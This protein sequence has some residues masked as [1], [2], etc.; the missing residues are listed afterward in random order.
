MIQRY[1][2]GEDEEL[3]LMETTAPPLRALTGEGGGSYTYWVLS[4]DPGTPPLF[5]LSSLNEHPLR[6]EPTTKF[7]LTSYK[8]LD[9]IEFTYQAL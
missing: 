2:R 4:S 1:V 8:V 3:N 9:I 5:Q 6:H 7:S